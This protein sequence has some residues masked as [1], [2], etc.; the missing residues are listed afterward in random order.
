MLNRILKKEDSNF[1]LS[2]KMKK[3]LFKSKIDHVLHVEHEHYFSKK[4]VL[5][6]RK[7]KNKSS[8]SITEPRCLICG[9]RLS[10]YRAEKRYETME[11]PAYKDG[12]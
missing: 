5:N 4:E 2:L 10:Q 7:K 11:I 1:N 3:D 12:K 9:L 6:F 8:K